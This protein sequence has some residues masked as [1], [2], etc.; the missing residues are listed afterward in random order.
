M[1]RQICIGFLLFTTCVGC[2]SRKSPVSMATLRAEE[3][4]DQETWSPI[5]VISEDG[6]PLIHLA[7]SYMARY[8]RPDSSYMVLTGVDGSSERVRVDLFGADGDSSA[9]VY[10][11]MLTYYDRERRFV[12]RGDVIVITRDDKRLESEHLAWTEIDRK[13]R[14]PGFVRI[15]SP[16]RDV[17]GYGLVAAED[18]SS[19]QLTRVTGTIIPDEG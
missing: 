2:G 3:A 11:D 14:T 19:F 7:A 8:D 10:S 15:I 9:V 13:V 5:L 16:N 18:L 4:P 1:R 6:R 12:A 17:S